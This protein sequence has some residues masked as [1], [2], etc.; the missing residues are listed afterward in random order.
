M[1][2]ASLVRRIGVLAL[3][4][5]AIAVG[6]AACSEPAPPPPPATPAVKTVEA[7]AQWYQDCWGMF[8][9][10]AWD[11]FEACY[12]QNAV[13]E[14]VDSAQPT[15]T[16]RANIIARSK[17]EETSFPDRRGEVR[18]M[19]ANGEKMASIAL[20]TATN[21]GALP[22]GPDGK[23]VPATGKAIGFLMGHTIETDATGSVA[24]REAAYLEEGTMMAQLGLSPAPARKAEK[25][26][27]AKA[28][29]V[30][31]KNDETEKANLAA[32]QAMFDALNKHDLK[33]IDSMTPADYKGIEVARPT[34]VGKKEA[35]AGMKEM[36]SAFPDV[37]ITPTTTWAA[38]PYVVITG[39]LEGTNT[40]DM[41]SMGLKK[42]GKKVTS[43]FLE[44]MRFDGGQVRED[45]LFYNSAA[46]AA[47]LGLK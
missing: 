35:M 41:P 28:T 39:T 1:S 13:S 8:N 23:P 46:W 15:V 20:Y 33:A 30:V 6:A 43:R 2:D 42:T 17:Q 29:V 45:W 10:K 25:A 31:A 37:R 22:P 11:K 5:A 3:F 38:G 36:F 7:R 18:L 44:I 16:G 9:D 47:Q 40:G 12:D 27:G 14:T 4:G 34:D 24:V 19:L 26:T 21:T 32:T